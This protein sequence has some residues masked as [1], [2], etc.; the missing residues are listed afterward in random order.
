MLYNSRVSSADQTATCV[1]QPCAWTG[2]NTGLF[3]AAAIFGAA[4]YFAHF[5]LPSPGLPLP[6]TSAPKCL[7]YLLG[8]VSRGRYPRKIISGSLLANDREMRVLYPPQPSM[9]DNHSSDV[10]APLHSWLTTKYGVPGI[11]LGWE[12]AALLPRAQGTDIE[13]S[14]TTDWR[15]MAWHSCYVDTLLLALCAAQLHHRKLHPEGHFARRESQST[16]FP[17]AQ[18]EGFERRVSQVAK[19]H[20]M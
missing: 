5:L 13:D 16:H 2:F 18:A 19:A 10:A 12:I 4:R 8:T 9:P 17:R 15:S 3:H 6:E 14:Y 1:N 7:R 20:F 11:S